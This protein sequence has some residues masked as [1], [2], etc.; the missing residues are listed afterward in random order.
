MKKVTGR[1]TRITLSDGSMEVIPTGDGT[2]YVP[3]T[4]AEIA[5][6]YFY[7]EYTEG[8]TVNMLRLHNPL[9]IFIEDTT[10]MYLRDGS[11][12]LEEKDY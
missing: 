9:A 6:G 12:E 5:A 3:A 10:E 2:L 8:D 11:E 1:V 7:V 4:D